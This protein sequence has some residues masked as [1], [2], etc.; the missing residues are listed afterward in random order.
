MMP[1]TDPRVQDVL[2]EYHRRIEVERARLQRAFADGT[3]GQIIVND[4]MLEP[5]SERAEVMRYQAALRAMPKMTS[6]LVPIGSG[7]EISRYAG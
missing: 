1:A 2:D 6:I 4:N 7:L 5:A 3:F